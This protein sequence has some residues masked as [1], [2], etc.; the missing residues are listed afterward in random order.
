V[1]SGATRCSIFA[2]LVQGGLDDPWAPLAEAARRNSSAFPRATFQLLWWDSS[3]LHRALLNLLDNAC[4][5]ARDH[6]VVEGALWGL[7]KPVGGKLEIPTTVARFNGRTNLERN[8][9]RLFIAG[10]SLPA[11]APPAGRRPG[12]ASR[13]AD[14]DHPRGRVRGRKPTPA[15]GAVM[16][17]GAA[18]GDLRGRVPARQQG[19]RSCSWANQLRSLQAPQV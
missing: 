15:V 19:Q 5:T 16:E 10:E 14:R 13:A 9:E 7:R 3:R 6:G 18:Q 8:V 1:M 4:A 11:S 12:L 2:E 17:L